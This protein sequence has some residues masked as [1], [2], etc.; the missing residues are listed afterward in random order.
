MSGAAGCGVSRRDFV[1]GAVAGA[2]LA[3]APASVL[4]AASG[5]PADKTAVLAEIP[6]MRAANVKRLQDWIALPS[7]AAENRNYPQG[8]DYMAK[9]ARDAGFTGVKLV[10]TSGKPG[11]FGRIDAGAKTSVGIYFMY[12]VK[13]Y[14]PEEWSSPP[15]EGRLVPK[16]GL[17]T[18]CVG[19]GAVNQKGP[20]N[21]FLSA[22]LAF[23]AAGRKLP[24][25]LVLVCEGEEEIGSPHF[26]EIV[27]NPEVMA[28]LKPC[29]GVVMPEAGQDRDGGV[30]VSL[31]AKGIIELE[32]VSTGEKW[33]R[34]P[35]HDVHSSLEAMVDSPTWHLVQALNTLVEKDGHTPAVEGLFEKAQPL[36]ALH[37]A[38]IANYAAK[39]SEDVRKKMLGVERWVHDTN[40]VEGLQLL[41]SRPTIN[42]EGL[43][44]GYTGPGGKTVLPHR[45]VAKIDM[46][47]VP[48]MTASDTLAKLKAHLAKHGFADIDVNMSG[49]YDPTQTDLN[50]KLIQ[51]QIATYRRLDVEPLL[52]PRGAG[53]WPGHVFTNP[54]L[55]L[56]AGHFGLGHG[57]GAHAPD[58]YY[59]IES[60]NSKVQGLD[61]AVASFV[62]YLYA[63]A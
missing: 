41:E 32:L 17:G 10:P 15:L 30:Q 34:G 55:S 42:I 50:S 44:A 11:V 22:L 26:G 31:G 38:M 57:S 45:A 4:A 28:A 21:A 13:Q 27:M 7:I 54:P 5:G 8:A 62:E 20:E 16:D 25:N 24:V 3:V 58:E 61:G 49:G 18:I 19:R 1:Q 43:V 53:S 2:A 59:L 46:R 14:L 39:T 36:S 51:T 40:W 6:K 60:A 9:L 63:L 33:G 56:P 47:L 29:L 52:W 12:D 35:K 48:D 23:Q 37:R